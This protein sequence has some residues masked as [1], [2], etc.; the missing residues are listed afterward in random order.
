MKLIST[1]VK[2]GDILTDEKGVTYTVGLFRKIDGKNKIELHQKINETSRVTM[3][4]STRELNKIIN[5][6]KN[7]TQ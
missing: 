4:V 3:L 6:F 7:T 1:S 2:T 5:Q